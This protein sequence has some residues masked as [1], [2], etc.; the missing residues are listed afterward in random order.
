ML[1]FKAPE[2][3]FGSLFSFRFP[4]ANNL[5]TICPRKKRTG[6]E[7]DGTKNYDPKT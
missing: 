2:L 6:E 1:V 5:S 3:R 7:H 4:I